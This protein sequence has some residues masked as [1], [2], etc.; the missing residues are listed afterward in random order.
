VRQKIE[1]RRQRRD[2]SQRERRE[3]RGRVE[4]MLTRH[5]RG[6][7]QVEILENMNEAKL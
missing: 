3:E 4:E 7:E 1:D 2:R 5:G 6:G